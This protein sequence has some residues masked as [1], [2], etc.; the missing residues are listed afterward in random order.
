MA[1]KRVALTIEI[2]VLARAKVHAGDIPL[3]R[4]IECLIEKEIAEADRRAT[5]I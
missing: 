3:S 1:H 4:W 5:E 2:D